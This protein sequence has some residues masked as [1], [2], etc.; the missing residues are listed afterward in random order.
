MADLGRPSDY[1]PETANAICTLIVDGMSLR[2]IC[3]RDGFPDVSTVYRWLANHEDFCE[4]YARAKEDQADTLADDIIDIADDGSNDY[5]T[6]TREDGS[7]YETVDYDHIARSRLRVDSRK[8]IAAKLKPKKYG[9]KIE[10]SG[11]VGVSLSEL[12]THAG[13]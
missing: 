5:V 7:T 4:Q 6:K 12:I 13:G 11:T 9:E 2:S 1:T 8:W 3:K 10:H